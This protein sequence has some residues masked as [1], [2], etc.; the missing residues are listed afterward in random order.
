VNQ[1]RAPIPSAT[2]L[3]VRD[4]PDLEVLMVVRHHQ[5]DFASGALVFPGGKLA[6]DDAAPE[7]RMLA[8]GAEGLSE[9]EISL[10]VGAIREAFEESGLI[11][12]R[13]GAQRGAGAPLAGC[14]AAQAIAVHRDAVARGE[15]AFSRVIADAGLA[16]ALDTLVDYAHWITPAIMPKRFDTYFFLAPAPQDQL[17]GHDGRETVDAAWVRPGAV[18]QEM[19]AGARKIIFPT[20][21]NIERLG[22]SV[23]VAQALTAARA[24]AHVVVEPVVVMEEGRAI[25]VI[26]AE[27]GYSVTREPLE[28]NQP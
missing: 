17:A 21:L 27:A 20:R 16:L 22:E 9:M 26:P 7:W 11:L 28:G 10:R 25:L 23:S 18:L 24:R 2:I 19:R 12:A 6:P 13:P 5:I 8:D 4:A 3:M 1:P 15:L 14:A